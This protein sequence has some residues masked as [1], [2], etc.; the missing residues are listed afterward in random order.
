MS[1]ESDLIVSMRLLIQMLEKKIISLESHIEK[2][3]CCCAGC[4]KHNQ[5]LLMVC[6]V[7]TAPVASIGE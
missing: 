1:K 3:S 2:M 6:N 4:T 7:P 5:D